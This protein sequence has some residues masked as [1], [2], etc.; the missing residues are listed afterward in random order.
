MYTTPWSKSL[1]ECTRK[2]QKAADKLNG[3]IIQFSTNDQ[4]GGGFNLYSATVL[5]EHK[6][7]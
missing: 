6:G 4:D 3:T 2:A 5:I 1:E 7:A